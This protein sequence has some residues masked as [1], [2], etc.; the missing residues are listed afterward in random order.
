MGSTFRRFVF[1]G[2]AIAV[3]TPFKGAAAG[4]VY[5]CKGPHGEVTFTNIKCPDQSKTQRYGSYT[6]APDAP[7]APR[8]E[9]T[10][11]LPA[12]PE[13]AAPR[14]LA[15]PAPPPIAG[16]ECAVN[17]KTWI[18]VSPCPPTSTHVVFEDVDVDGTTNTGQPINGTGTVRR[19]E[20]V[21]VSQQPLG[22]DAMCARIAARANTSEKGDNGPSASYERNR[23][24]E[25][26][27]CH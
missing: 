10:G 13:N 7:L 9:E 1:A 12:Q 5:K 4:E 16:Y 23:M 2:L 6:N 27:G 8:Q 17:G 21:P 25:T 15:S 14:T 20:T 19:D 22:H 11:S 18:Q 24:R 3:I 26:V